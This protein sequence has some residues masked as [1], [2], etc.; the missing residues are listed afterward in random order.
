MTDSM[1]FTV[2]LLV[3]VLGVAAA[4][5][6]GWIW[7][8]PLGALGVLALMTRIYRVLARSPSASGQPFRS[9]PP[10]I[11]TQTLWT[12]FAASCVLG[13]G[14]A[15][16]MASNPDGYMQP[17]PPGPPWALIVPGTFVGAVA[18]AVLVWLLSRATGARIGP[19]A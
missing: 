16:F 19:K 17:R 18:G 5:V 12:L 6:V 11:Q 14:C 4:H 8:G 9:R 7:I 15:G 3:T 13:G 1:R 10:G 2:F